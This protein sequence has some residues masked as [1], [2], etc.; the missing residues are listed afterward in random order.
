[1]KSKPEGVKSN[2]VKPERVTRED[3]L[4]VEERGSLSLD[5]PPP[6][7]NVWELGPQESVTWAG[8]VSNTMAQT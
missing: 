5:R 8:E 7:E 6:T 2:V 4:Q 3:T 1:M